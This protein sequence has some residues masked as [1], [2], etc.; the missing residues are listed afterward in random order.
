MELVKEETGIGLFRQ[1]LQDL[2]DKR[3]Y[4]ILQIL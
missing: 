1:D 4:N 3:Y 2:Q